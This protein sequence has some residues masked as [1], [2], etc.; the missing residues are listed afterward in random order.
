MNILV[1]G[2]GAREHAIAWKLSSSPQVDRIFMVPGNAGSASIATT[3]DGSQ[4]DIDGLARLVKTHNVDLTIVGPETPLAN[5][6]VDLFVE[7][8][9][10]IFGPTKMAA[11]IEVSKA[12]AK[13]LSKKYGIPC[14]DFRVFHAYSEAHSFLSKHE[15]PVVVKADGLAAG[16]GAIVCQGKEEALSSLYDCMKARVFGVAGDTVV[17]EEYL[18]GLEVSVFAFSDGQHLS[19]LTAACDYKRLMD[20]DSGPNTGGMGS[21]TSPE[22]WTPELEDQVNREIMVPAAIGLM[23]AGTPYQGVLYAGL[24][25]TSRGPK[26][27]EFNCR[28]GDP[29][30]QVILPL[31]K[32][33]LVDVFLACIGGGLHKL[34]I[35]W[36]QGFCVGV[37]L[38]SGGYPGEYAR[39]LPISGLEDVDPDIL[40]FHAATKIRDNG[41]KKRVLTDGGRVLTLVGLGPT[42]VQAR[43]RAYDNI[44]R[45]NFPNAQ[46]RR[47]IGLPRK[48]AT[49]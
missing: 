19:P 1:V 14:P 25:I 10:A 48:A 31:L 43:E 34:S 21:Y 4:D 5:G 16:K 49:A 3:L 7:R 38:A 46:Y 39:G 47:D 28:L 17:I 22:F 12:F 6:I 26:V 45:V 18:E 30:A 20:D 11:Q 23:E 13:E 24:M 15:G 27:L 40:V 42:L 8:G 37:V 2:S 29:E 33:D 44:Q 41:E 9:L 36:D 32:T 35:G